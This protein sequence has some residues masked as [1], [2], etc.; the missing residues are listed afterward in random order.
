M[1]TEEQIKL[2]QENPEEWRRQRKAAIKAAWDAALA[3]PVSEPVSE[4]V[5]KARAKK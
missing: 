4:P 5:P 2:A 1:A 3:E